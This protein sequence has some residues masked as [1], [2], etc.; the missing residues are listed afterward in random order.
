MK[1]AG[2]SMVRK[3]SENSPQ[4]LAP[5][6]VDGLQTGRLVPLQALDLPDRSSV[7]RDSLVSRD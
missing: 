4:A 2:T 3:S 6:R 5:G 7:F 1:S